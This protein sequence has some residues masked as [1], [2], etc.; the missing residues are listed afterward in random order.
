MNRH[1]AGTA[2]PTTAAPFVWVAGIA[3]VII[4]ALAVV[5]RVPTYRVAPAFLLPILWGMLLLRGR[6][7]V[8]ALGYA[9]FALAVVLHGLGA[10][11]FYQRSFFGVSFDVYV[12]FYFAFAAALLVERFLRHVLPLRGWWLR[13]AT[14]LCI[15]GFGAIHEIVEF[16]SYLVLGERGMLKTGSYRFDTSRDLTMNLLGC[17][18]GLVV[19]AVVGRAR[20]GR[21]GRGAE[22][23]D[24]G[25]IEVPA[26]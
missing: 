11:G 12:H 10:L 6:L 20:R 7:H 22:R 23:E 1:A 21:E 14:V 18:L 13:A 24:R 4:V 2:R 3:S 5:A 9:M 17:A 16:A 19:I 15:M 26:R 8:G 25:V